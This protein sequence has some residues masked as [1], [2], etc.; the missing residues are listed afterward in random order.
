MF[1]ALKTLFNS[2]NSFSNYFDGKTHEILHTSFYRVKKKRIQELIQPR[3]SDTKLRKGLTS[4]V[5]LFCFLLPI[6]ILCKELTPGDNRLWLIGEFLLI[7]FLKKKRLEF[8]LT[9]INTCRKF[10]DWHITKLFLFVS[11]RKMFIYSQRLAMNYF[12]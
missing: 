8:S 9:V 4:R 5:K 12:K 3:Q 10:V 6:E 7:L 2:S 11:R 1:N